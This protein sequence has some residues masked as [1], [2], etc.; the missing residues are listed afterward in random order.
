MSDEVLWA[1]FPL[2]GCIGY[3]GATTY[4]M[5]YGVMSINVCYLPSVFIAVSSNK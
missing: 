2:N 4:I 5:C 3:L 1:N